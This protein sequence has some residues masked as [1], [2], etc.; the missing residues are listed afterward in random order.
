VK[1]MGP[2]A[3]HLSNGGSDARDG[4]TMSGTG[5]SS[6]ELFNNGSLSF[7]WDA[8]CSDGMIFGPFPTLEWSL[9]MKVVTKETRGLEVSASGPSML[10]RM[11][12]GT[13]RFP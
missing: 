6:W 3:D 7:G 9:N 13:S 2:P 4:Y 1:F 10:R 12:S 11:I 5:S 8:C